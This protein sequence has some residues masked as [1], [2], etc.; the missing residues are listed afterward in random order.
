MYIR[1]AELVGEAAK[2]TAPPEV[3]TFSICDYVG[4]G[5]G[6]VE[7]SLSALFI[8][9]LCN[10]EWRVLFMD[11]RCVRKNLDEPLPVFLPKFVFSLSQPVCMPGCLSIGQG[12]R[13]FLFGASGHS[14]HANKHHI[15]VPVAF[16]GIGHI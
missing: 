14:K 11:K 15:A 4:P 9:A 8:D 7:F 6:V 5:F 1:P 12:L 13:C 2:V 16:R 10:G 3:E